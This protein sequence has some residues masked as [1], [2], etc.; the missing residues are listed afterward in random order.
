MSDP[1][2]LTVNSWSSFFKSKFLHLFY[3]G[4][5][6][7]SRKTNKQIKTKPNRLF[8]LFT[9]RFFTKPMNSNAIFRVIYIIWVSL[10]G[11]WCF[12]Y[13]YWFTDWRHDGYFKEKLLR[14]N[15]QRLSSFSHLVNE[16]SEKIPMWI[17]LLNIIMSI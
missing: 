5:L 6:S 10:F 4:T 11:F 2:V 15:H 3:S 13:K 12:V 7:T 1:L 17:V 9:Q 14:S 16:N 8:S